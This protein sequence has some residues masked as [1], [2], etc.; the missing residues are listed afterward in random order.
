ME[1]HMGMHGPN[2]SAIAM[3]ENGP[4][5]ESVG[6]FQDCTSAEEHSA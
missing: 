5:G 2:V 1:L 4:L 3:D 6:I